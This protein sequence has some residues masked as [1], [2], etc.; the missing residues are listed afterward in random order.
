M[1]QNFLI[2]ALS[3]SL[4]YENY[5]PDLILLVRETEKTLHL[6]EKCS[7]RKIKK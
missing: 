6:E 4:G 7:L 3:V 2:S 1:S 5:F